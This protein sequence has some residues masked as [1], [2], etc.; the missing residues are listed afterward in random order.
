VQTK[1]EEST[2]TVFAASKRDGAKHP[3]DNSIGKIQ[4]QQSSSRGSEKAFR[5]IVGNRVAAVMRSF[6]DTLF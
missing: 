4:A 2:A 1:V 3:T 6:A 5:K